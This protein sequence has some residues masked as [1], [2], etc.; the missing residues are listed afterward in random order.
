MKLE[1]KTSNKFEVNARVSSSQHAVCSRVERGSAGWIANA[2]FLT[3]NE[4]VGRG[5]GAV[6]ICRKPPSHLASA[7]GLLLSPSSLIFLRGDDR[8]ARERIRGARRG[9]EMRHDVLTRLSILSEGP[10]SLPRLHLLRLFRHNAHVLERVG[11]HP[12][13]RLFLLFIFP[14]DLLLLVE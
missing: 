11:G 10:R 13:A 14:S 12:R 3:R 5:E 4:K 9:W 6:G 2:V 7:A 1:R 8:R